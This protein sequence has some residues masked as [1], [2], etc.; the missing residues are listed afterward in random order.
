MGEIFKLWEEKIPFY[1]GG[2]E[3][4][5]TYYP[6]PIKSGKGSV[7]ICPGGGYR[8]RCSTYEGED[9]A[10]YLNCQGLDAFVLDYRVAPNVHPTPLADARRAIRFVRHNAKKFGLNPE[11]IA[12]MGSSAGGHLAAHAATFIGEIEGETGDE[13]DKESYIPNAQ[14]LCY[15]VL[16][17]AGHLGSYKNLLGEDG[18]DELCESV[19]PK[20]IATEMTPP[21][22]I[23]HTAEDQIVDVSNSYRYATR[24]RELS[25]PTEMHIFPFGGHGHGLANTTQRAN[26]H[27]AVWGELLIRW[28]RLF[29][30]FA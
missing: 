1:N 14:I 29:G 19:T 11:K 12:I 17:K 16:D 10:E 23:W 13:I 27:V 3:P 6:S 26:P 9:Y 15:P 28:L 22:F 5:L 4:W 2:E 8:V 18:A 30:F 7:I 20:N 24:L 21:A 25:I